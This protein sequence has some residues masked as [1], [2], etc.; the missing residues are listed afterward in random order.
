MAEDCLVCLIVYDGKEFP[1]SLGRS[2]GVET[3]AVK[4]ATSM[5]SGTPPLLCNQVG[6]TAAL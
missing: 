5:R 3:A 6:A 1:V 2:F 4:A